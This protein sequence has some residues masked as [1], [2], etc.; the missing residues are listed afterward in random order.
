MRILIACEFYYPSVGGV[1]EVMRQIAE[2]L[3]E[4]GHGVT[5]ATSYLPQRQIYEL[6]GVRIVE[7]KVAGNLVQGIAGD[8]DTYRNYV[9]TG[10]YDVL[11]VK[12]AQQ[13]TLDALLP[14]LDRLPKSK[15]F[16]PCGFS[17]L[18]EPAY[19]EYF[20]SMPAVLRKFEHLIFYAS[21][22]RDINFARAHGLSNFS[23]VPNGA[24]EREFAP[25]ADPA[26]RRRHGI[27]EDAFVLLTVGSLTGRKG[28][29]E[30][31]AAFS[32][33][34]LRD[35]PAVLI[36]NGSDPQR[37]DSSRPFARLRGVAAYMYRDGGAWVVLKWLLAKTLMSMKLAC[38]LGSRGRS[39]RES[40]DELV[41]R[42]NREAPA[43]RALL[44]DLPRAELVQ[45]Y[46]NSDLFVFASN[47]EY[48][49][50][51]LYEAAA[52]GLPFL[53]V[54]VG[55]AVEIARET[56]GGAIC[57]AQADSR[58]YT[59]V[60]PAVLAEQIERL[61]ADHAMLSTLADAGRKSWME[62]FTWEKIADQYEAVLSRL[63]KERLTI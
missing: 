12:A 18:Y 45:A 58:G 42:I 4:R 53:T 22:Y 23:I 31:A 62:K 20:D 19:A 44:V 1:Q 10:D 49:P 15:I 9:M 11:M 40:I 29:Q 39:V 34:R 35:Q 38:L 60:A 43:K 7:F 24:C 37:N 14:I 41:V 6:N 8:A 36:L 21:D 47:I 48:S 56:G 32:L 17:G 51:V 27:E 5:V 52:A 13:W 46:L 25:A 28:H 57:P 33:I 61:A 50:L 3:V 63:V 16:I 30:L 2:R 59:N 55:N 26:F 54:P